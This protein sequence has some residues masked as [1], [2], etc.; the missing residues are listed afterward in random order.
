MVYEWSE[1]ITE[2]FMCDKN[3]LIATFDILEDM[4]DV[5]MIFFERNSIYFYYN[6]VPIAVEISSLNSAVSIK[7]VVNLYISNTRVL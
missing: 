4:S 1:D 2:F 6:N 3:T 5:T 7:S